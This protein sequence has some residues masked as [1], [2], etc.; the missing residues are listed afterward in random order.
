MPGEVEVHEVCLEEGPLDAIAVEQAVVVH[1]LD[2]EDALICDDE[3]VI[4]LA[5]GLVDCPD[6]EL[7]DCVSALVLRPVMMNVGA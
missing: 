6:V 3:T 4:N 7:L 1:G 2:L 5:G